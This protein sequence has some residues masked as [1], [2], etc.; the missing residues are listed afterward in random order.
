MNHTIS[1]Y[2]KINQVV[3]SVMKEKKMQGRRKSDGYA[4]KIRMSGRPK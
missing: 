1:K 4:T 2:M 3:E